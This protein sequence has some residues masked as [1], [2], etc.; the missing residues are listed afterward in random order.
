VRKALPKARIRVRLDG[1]FATPEMFGFLLAQQVEYVVAMA[2][3]AVF[4]D[5]ATYLM[6]EAQDRSAKIGQTE[7]VYGECRYAARTWDW[8]SRVIIKAEVT[9][10]RAV[11]PKTTPVSW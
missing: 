3:N 8:E 7:K 1:G 11:S 10:L 5:K 6:W 2:K 4:E 9:R